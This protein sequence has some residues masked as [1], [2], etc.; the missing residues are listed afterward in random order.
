MVAIELYNTH[1][2]QHFVGLLAKGC[3]FMRGKQ[4]FE[5]INI[6]CKGNKKKTFT[7]MEGQSQSK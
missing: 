7:Q 3:Y 5:L 4:A 1:K 2:L 6:I